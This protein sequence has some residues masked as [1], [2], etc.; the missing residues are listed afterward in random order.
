[1]RRLET[2]LIAWLVQSDQE[3]ASLRGQRSNE[4]TPLRANSG[5]VG[6]SDW[7]TRVAG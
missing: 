6:V 2:H 7:A 4:T 5:G 3:K 1:M